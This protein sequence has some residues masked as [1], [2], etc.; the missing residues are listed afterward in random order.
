MHYVSSCGNHG[1]LSSLKAGLMPWSPSICQ[2]VEEWRN[3][4]AKHEYRS[5]ELWAST[6]AQE[7]GLFVGLRLHEDSPTQ[8]R[9]WLVLQVDVRM[10]GLFLLWPRPP[11][12]FCFFRLIQRIYRTRRC[13]RHVCFHSSED[14]MVWPDISPTLLP[15]Y[16]AQCFSSVF[17]SHYPSF[18]LIS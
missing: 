4:Q 16:L 3:T 9:R 2:V 18:S 11:F 5:N 6:P 15:F 12:I 10:W 13:G 7:E 14:G 17:F 1:L 8:R